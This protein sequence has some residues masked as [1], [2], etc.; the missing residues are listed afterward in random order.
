MIVPAAATPASP[1]AS[2]AGWLSHAVDVL[3]R[4]GAFSR[5]G[6]P[7]VAVCYEKISISGFFVVLLAGC[8]SF[9]MISTTTSPRRT[10]GSPPRVNRA[11]S[12][13]RSPR[14]RSWCSLRGATDQG[15]RMIGW[16]FALLTVSKLLWHRGNTSRWAQLCESLLNG[17]WGVRTDV[18]L[19]F[20]ACMQRLGRYFPRPIDSAGLISHVDHIGW[21][22]A[23][24][25]KGGWR[26]EACWISMSGIVIHLH[27][28]WT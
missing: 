2:T 12:S 27:R 28:G 9:W 21:W 10:H 13:P 5:R 17:L 20:C 16:R 6:A 3:A 25:R 23:P 26:G 1:S 19:F 8:A 7:I 15:N 4:Y 14:W 18:L 11:M 24:K 22:R